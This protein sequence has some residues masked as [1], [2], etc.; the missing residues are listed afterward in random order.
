MT[1]WVEPSSTT[2]GTVRLLTVALE[3]LGYSIAELRLA[4]GEVRLLLR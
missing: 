1:A 2:W 4:S 3:R